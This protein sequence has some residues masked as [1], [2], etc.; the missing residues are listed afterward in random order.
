MV[1]V[2]AKPID[3]LFKT[4]WSVELDRPEEAAVEDSFS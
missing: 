1:T 2:V 4:V 3:E